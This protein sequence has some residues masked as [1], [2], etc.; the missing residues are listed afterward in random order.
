ME[1]ARFVRFVDE[2]ARSPTT[3]L[4]RLTADPTSANNCSRPRTSSPSPRGRWSGRPPPTRVWRSF[5][6]RINGRYARHVAIG[7]RDQHRRL[8]R[9]SRS[10]DSASPCQQPTEAW[11][12]LQLGNCGS[13][14]RNRRRLAGAHPRC[15]AHAH[16]QH[17]CDPARPRRSDP[18][19]R[20]AAQPLLSPAHD[21][22]N[23]YVPNVVYSCGALVHADTLVIPTGSPTAPSALPPS[24]SRN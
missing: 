20:P 17:R 23:G 12:A 8:R 6:R 1:D 24:R 22:Q 18:G 19:A 4:I 10:L 13:A 5:P 2:T 15:R 3:P 14:N 7:P 9:R 11:E 21:E 16:V